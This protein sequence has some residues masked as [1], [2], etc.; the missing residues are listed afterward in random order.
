[1]CWPVLLSCGHARQGSPSWSAQRALSRDRL[2]SYVVANKAKLVT[3]HTV[4]GGGLALVSKHWML[5]S[6]EWWCLC[7]HSY[8]SKCSATWPCF[9]LE[10][11]CS[12]LP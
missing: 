4:L 1:M 11:A 5:Q 3:P 9:V 12:T 8:I 2:V 10:L 7:E 6:L